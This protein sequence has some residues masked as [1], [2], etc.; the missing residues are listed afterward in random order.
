LTPIVSRNGRNEWA[1]NLTHCKMP[2]YVTHPLTILTPLI[3]QK[4]RE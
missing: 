2:E 1:P 4:A 3:S